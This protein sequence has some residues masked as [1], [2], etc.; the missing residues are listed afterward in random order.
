MNTVVVTSRF[1]F[2]PNPTGDRT[3]RF[4]YAAIEAPEDIGDL[5][6]ARAYPR[7]EPGDDHLTPS[8]HAP[9][10][11]HRPHEREPDHARQPAPR[12]RP[13]PETGHHHRPFDP[14][15]GHHHRPHVKHPADEFITPH[16]RRLTDA[17]SG[18]DKLSEERQGARHGSRAYRNRN[19]G[20]IKYGSFARGHGAIGQDSGGFAIFPND[21]AGERAHRALWNRHDYSDVPIGH[22]LSRWGTMSLPGVDSSKKWRDLSPEQQQNLLDAQKRR[23]GW[24]VGSGSGSG[25]G[26]LTPEHHGRYTGT[27]D[28][29]GDQF[30]FVSG[31][32]GAGSSPPGDR[33]VTG[34]SF[35]GRLGGGEGRFATEDVYDPQA[36]RKRSLVRIHASSS[37]DIDHAVSSGCFGVEKSQWPRLK[38]EL[39]AELAAHGGKMMLHVGAD[40]N[41]SITPVGGAGQA[42]AYSPHVGGAPKNMADVAETMIGLRDR[43]PAGYGKIRQYLATGGAG[44]D[45]RTA[46]WCASFV[47]ATARH[48]GMSTPSNANVATEWESFGTPV[49]PE[50]VRRGDIMI[51]GT[52]GRRVGATGGHVAIVGPLS[53]GKIPIIEGDQRTDKGSYAVNP[54]SMHSTTRTGPAY[55]GG[56]MVGRNEVSITDEGL[57]FRRPPENSRVAKK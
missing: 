22:A 26:G 35:G 4:S 39:N 49:R 41:A 42:K 1:L 43:D 10:H 17:P 50:D 18:L 46:N 9:G 48:A 12:T 34:Q 21:A 45:P 54:G 16:D 40:G 14:E 47:A 7:P 24:S 11:H 13:R 5:Y 8:A 33:L 32:R 31:G 27:L 57:M 55:T 20:N 6:G 52:T 37:D 30:R 2:G 25:S 51:G 3:G 15:A 44:M 19:P 23:E 38:K 36:G 53:G 29:G 28:I 56:H